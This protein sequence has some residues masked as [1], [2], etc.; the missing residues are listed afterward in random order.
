MHSK[1]SEAADAPQYST[2]SKALLLVGG[3]TLLVRTTLGCLPTGAIGVHAAHAALSEC[4]IV[5]NTATSGAALLVTDSSS[6]HVAKSNLT[7]NTA[8]VSGGA[9]QVIVC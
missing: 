2:D 4:A 5:H 7:D 9:L 6:V 1:P 3:R 8:S